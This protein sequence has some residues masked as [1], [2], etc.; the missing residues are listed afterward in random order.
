MVV[1]NSVHN[2]HRAEEF[3]RNHQTIHCFLDNDESGKRT[4]EAVQK[5]GREVIDQSPFYR[6]HKDLNEYLQSKNKP[7]QA[8]PRKG[9]RF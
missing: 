1:L 9:I 6:N 3:L 7:I 2:L 4:L 5:L 8:K